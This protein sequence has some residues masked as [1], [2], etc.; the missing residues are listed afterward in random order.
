MKVCPV[1]TGPDEN[2]IELLRLAATEITKEMNGTRPHIIISHLARYIHIRLRENHDLNLINN[3]M[4]LNSIF[5]FRSRLD[6]NRE[7]FEAA[8]GDPLALQ[9]YKEF[10]T[11]IN[12]AKSVVRRGI[13]IDFHGF[14]VDWVIEL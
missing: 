10:H 14:N 9:A 8:Q 7:D 5:Y 13:L 11:S 6:P 4:S 3:L 1:A 12:H 2:T